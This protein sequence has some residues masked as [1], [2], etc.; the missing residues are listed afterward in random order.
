MRVVLALAALCAV[1]A[2]A[3][4]SASAGTWSGKTKQGRAVMLRTD[5]DGLVTRARIG[6]KARCQDGTYSS[7]TIFLPPFDTSSSSAFSAAGDYTARP[8][9]Y[10][11]AIH[12]TVKGAWVD[13]SD[14]WHGTF[15]VRVRVRKD[16]KL[17]D[18]CRLKKLRWSA[19]R[20]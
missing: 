1:V 14:R 5:G 15:T 20:A 10:V 16:G 2:A 3:P 4:A 9:G 17:V 7:R 6:W 18:T 19:G 11:S 12:V 13:A 8:K